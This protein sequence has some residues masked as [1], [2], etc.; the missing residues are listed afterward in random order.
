MSEIKLLVPDWNHD[1]VSIGYPRA[2]LDGRP[3]ADPHNLGSGWVG[4]PHVAERLA[5]ARQASSNLINP[6]AQPLFL[7]PARTPERG[8]HCPPSHVGQLWLS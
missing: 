4:R 6:E 8:I 3:A 7:C 5:K 1:A 2:V